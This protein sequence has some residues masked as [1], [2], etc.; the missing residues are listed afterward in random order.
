MTINDVIKKSALLLFNIRR[1][2]YLNSSY[3]QCSFI[4]F[5]LAREVVVL[6]M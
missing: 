2:G 6:I 1:M 3:T 4:C 5:T